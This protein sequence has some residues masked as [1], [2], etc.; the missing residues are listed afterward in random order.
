M[1]ESLKAT[2]LSPNDVSSDYEYELSGR[3]L[4]L[5]YTELSESWPRLKKNIPWQNK[6]FNLGREN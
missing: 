3:F 6:E 2:L 4:N 1:L 5:N